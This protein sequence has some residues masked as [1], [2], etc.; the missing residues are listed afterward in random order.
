[1]E[2]VQAAVYS[3]TDLGVQVLSPA[4]PRV[5]DA[6]GD[7]LFVASDRLRNIRLVQQRHLMAIDASDFL[8]LVCPDGYVGLSASMEIGCAVT[9]GKPIFS[10][11]A[12]T[13]LT[14]RQY[15]HIV[16]TMPEAVRLARQG[17]SSLQRE[18]ALIDAK[19]GIDFAHGQL[20]ILEKELLL[21][22]DPRAELGA[23]NAARNVRETIRGL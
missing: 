3:L 12:P 17:Q 6:F 8:W 19:R 21:P 15:V 7:F 22:T 23:I 11:T 20:D 2:H 10:T 5:V 18:S 14:L 13:D 9:Q 1:M 16:A 4:D